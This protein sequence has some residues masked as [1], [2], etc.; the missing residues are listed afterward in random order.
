[1]S[2]TKAQMPESLWY[3]IIGPETAREI[4]WIE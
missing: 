2:E 1:M 4:N 3:T